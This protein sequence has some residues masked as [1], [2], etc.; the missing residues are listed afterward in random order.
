MKA[1]PWCNLGDRSQS[2]LQRNDELEKTSINWKIHNHKIN[3]EYE[4]GLE[5]EHDKE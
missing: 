4:D 3:M 2:S 1:V 5:I